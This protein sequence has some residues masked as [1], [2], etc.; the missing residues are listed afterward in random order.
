[1]KEEIIKR[2]LSMLYEAFPDKPPYISMNAAAKYCHTDAR[3]L[4]ADRTF[5][6]KRLGKRT[7]V[8]LVAL[9]HWLSC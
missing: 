9:A 7:V 1:M 6:K 8:P 3:R 2:T 5:P 4:E